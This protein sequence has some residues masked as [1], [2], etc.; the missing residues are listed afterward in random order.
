M[1]CDDGSTDET[2][3]IA[4][5]YT[6]LDA[7]FRV[8]RREHSGLVAAL[9]EGLRNCQA[10]YVARLDADDICHRQRLG[11]QWDY[12]ERHPECSGIGCSV[13]MFPR[14][15]LTENRRAYEAWL[16]AF[17]SESEILRERFVECPLAHPTWFFKR[18]VLLAFGYDNRGWPED[19]DLLLRLLGAG[20]RI[21]TLP[22]RLVSWRDSRTRLS[23]TD[24]RY[25]ID[26]FT[27]CRAHYIASQWLGSSSRYGLWGYGSTGKSLARALIEYGK[28][29]AF[30]V[31]LHPG[32]VGQK[33][34]GVPVIAP[35]QILRA[36]NAGEKLVI[37]VAGFRQ[38]SEARRFALAQG[39]IECVDFVC[40]A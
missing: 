9:N 22:A 5:H 15:G 11:M 35:S 10:S 7:R 17:A 31:E 33:I 26:A 30:I 14:S 4:C 25:A 28:R 38:R 13:R 19:Y 18:E 21:S 2:L 8:I 27:R 40:A 20:H 3:A 24:S 16:N 36:R 6:A 37:S 12:M 32:R 39:L 29:P 34:L 1:L 23:R